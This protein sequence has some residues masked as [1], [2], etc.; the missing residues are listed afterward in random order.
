MHNIAV[1]THNTTHTHTYIY[2][3]I[4]IRT[5]V[6]GELFIVN[7][8]QQRTMLIIFSERNNFYYL[9]LYDKALITFLRGN[10]MCEMK[11]FFTPLRCHLTASINIDTLYCVF[12]QLIVTLICKQPRMTPFCFE[13]DEGSKMTR[14]G[15]GIIGLY[16]TIQIILFTYL[17]TEVCISK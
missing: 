12:F 17:L 15:R 7:N 13:D 10:F 14:R 2:I 11:V 3:Y 9:I 6:I 8:T 16:G 5:I 1:N 4:Y